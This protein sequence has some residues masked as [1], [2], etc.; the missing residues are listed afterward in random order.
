MENTCN[1]DTC[2]VD[3]CNVDTCNVDTCNVDTCNVDTCSVDT[4]NVDTCNVDTCSVDTCS[5]DTCSVD[6]CNVDTCSVDTCNV[7]TCNVDTCNVD[8]CS[9]DTSKFSRNKSTAWFR[10]EFINNKKNVVIFQD[11][12]H[13]KFEKP[14][15]THDY[16]AF[17]Q[18]NFQSSR[19]FQLT[20]HVFC[21][22]RIFEDCFDDWTPCDLLLSNDIARSRQ[23]SYALGVMR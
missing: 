20:A 3:T 2:N 18:P 19:S 23:I 12:L 16:P 11:L 21:N 5:V 1:V 8:T 6:T 9:I 13:K 10:G 17:L 22:S 7:D 14:E 15:N 4:C